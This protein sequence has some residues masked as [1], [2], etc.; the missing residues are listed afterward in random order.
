MANIK[1]QTLTPVHIGSG[2]DLM[3]NTEFLLDNNEI[4]VVDEKKVLKI[5]GKEN[6]D[7]WLNI[8]NRGENLLDYIKLR[9]SN[10]SLDEISNR[11]MAVY[12][13]NLAKKQTLKEQLHSAKL[14]PMIPGSSIKGAIRTAIIAWLVN[15]NSNEVASIIKN[16][17]D[18]FRSKKKYWQ[19]GL[20]DFQK[21]E[22]TIIN[23]LLSGSSKMNANKNTFRFLQVGDFVFNYNTIASNMQVMNY[24]TTYW[25]TKKG[26]D[27]LIEMIGPESI[28]E[29]RIKINKSLLDLN[30]N[31]KELSSDT[32][33]LSSI[34][35]LFEIT[36][37]HTKFLIERELELWDDD[38]ADR[39][40]NL[41]NYI[42]TLKTLKNDIKNCGEKET[43]IRIG[44]GSG[45]DFITG[46]WAKTNK[47]LFDGD[48]YD[49]LVSLLNKG[50]NVNYFPKTRKMDEDGD[51]MGFIKL[52]EI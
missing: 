34:K 15:I 22:K 50:R 52:S 47:E 14:L 48:E 42:E 13:S 43:I 29:G 40:E 9:N 8:I 46:A 18:L 1:I 21:V 39:N 35:Q 17:K 33:F 25:D 6:I 32:S 10:I 20:N 5:I 41:D 23:K 19:W 12:G 38:D 44:G 27:Q 49:K 3:R 4:G 11:T 45:W 28:A 37:N 36:K 16:Q 2:R 26:S 7:K 31:K 51:T 30:I 24:H